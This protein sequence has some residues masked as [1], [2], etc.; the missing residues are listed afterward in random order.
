[1]LNKRN[2]IRFKTITNIPFI[3]FNNLKLIRLHTEKSEK[4]M[5]LQPPELSIEEQILEMCSSIKEKVDNL[6][7]KSL[8]RRI[9]WV[10]K[11]LLLLQ[12]F[13]YAHMLFHWSTSKDPKT[14]WLSLIINAVI[15]LALFGGIV[16]TS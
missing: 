3:K 11:G 2:S 7:P 9:R 4:L 13:I 10:C 5:K 8:K 16:A 6:T 1:M 15:G 12:G 14:W